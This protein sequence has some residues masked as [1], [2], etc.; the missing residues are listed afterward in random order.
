MPAAAQAKL[1]RDGGA[2]D[3][4]GWFRA[5]IP[6][7]VRVV[8]AVIVISSGGRHGIFEDLYYRL[9]VMEV[10][11]PLA[12]RVD[13]FAAAGRSTLWTNWRLYLD[14]PRN[15]R[16]TNIGTDGGIWLAG[17]VREL[18]NFVERSL[19]LGWFDLCRPEP[20]NNT[21]SLAHP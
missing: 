6:V 12:E 20:Q 3:T 2:A 10:T 9:Q 11:L 1:L 16:S 4:P 17:N 15:P 14:V 8:A 5:E 21:C 7:D 18:K 19:I 13:D